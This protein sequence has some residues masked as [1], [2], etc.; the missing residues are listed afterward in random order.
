[1][2]HR[3]VRN[4]N[5]GS[6]NCRYC[7]HESGSYPFNNVTCGFLRVGAYIGF[8]DAKFRHL[9]IYAGSRCISS[10]NL[11][12]HESVFVLKNRHQYLRDDGGLHHKSLI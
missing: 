12:F 9:G 4:L 1:M 10:T 5:R 8:K 6:G 2:A 3:K 11:P 7:P